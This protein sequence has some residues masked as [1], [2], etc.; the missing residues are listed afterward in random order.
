MSQRRPVIRF[1][2]EEMEVPAEFQRIEEHRERARV[3]IAA[4]KRRKEQERLAAIRAVEYAD[5][6]SINSAMARILAPKK[7]SWIKRLFNRT[8]DK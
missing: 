4:Y 8:E 1:E 7:P 6:R 2:D 3:A 5:S